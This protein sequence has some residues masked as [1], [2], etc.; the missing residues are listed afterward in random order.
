MANSRSE[1]ERE[2]KARRALENELNDDL[3]KLRHDAGYRPKVEC[4]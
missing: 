3:E 4:A 1:F 2:E